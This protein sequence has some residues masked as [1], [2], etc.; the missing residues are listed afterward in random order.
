MKA[1]IVIAIVLCIFT[2]FLLA[3]KSCWLL[4]PS[5]ICC[6][7]AIIWLASEHEKIVKR[8]RAQ[9]RAQRRSETT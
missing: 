8:E 7:L 9:A 5:G 1:L 6:L 3:M 4:F 2:P